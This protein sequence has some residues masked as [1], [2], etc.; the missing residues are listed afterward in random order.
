LEKGKA[1]LR[2]AKYRL[3]AYDMGIGFFEIIL[4]R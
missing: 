2:V 4:R 1:G 3:I